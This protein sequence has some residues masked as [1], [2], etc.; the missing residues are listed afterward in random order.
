MTHNAAT[1]SLDLAENINKTEDAMNHQVKREYLKAVYSRYKKESRRGKSKVLD[2]MTLILGC[3]RKW[4]IKLL[5]KNIPES[6]P[7]KGRPHRYPQELLVPI[8]Y[9]LWCKMNRVNSKRFKVALPLWIDFFKD[10]R[11]TPQ[12]RNWLLGMSPATIDRLL[13]HGRKRKGIC[14]TRPSKR[15]LKGIPIQV[16]DWNV[17]RP[18]TVQTDTVAHTHT[19]LDGKFAN[20]ITM[21][22]IHSSWTENRAVWT[23]SHRNM[24]TALREIE[25]A[26]PFNIEVFKSDSG[27]EFMNWAVVGHYQKRIK[28][29]TVVRSRPYRKNDNCYVEQK[30]FTHV[31]EI[32][33]YEKIDQPELIEWMNR[34]YREYWNP[35]HN[36]FL[37][38]QK[39]IRKTRIGSQIKKEY[40]E[41]KTPYQRIL[42]AEV[43]QEHKDALIKNKQSLNPVELSEQLERELKLFQSK[44]RSMRKWAA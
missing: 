4:A 30:N 17:V 13:Q 14:S 19:S 21:T 6:K 24:I 40:D 12:I 38:S 33:G 37:P 22:D 11:I 31:R 29:V 28:P 1:G 16:K 10:P 5:S 26:L 23:K 42:D 8:L 2:E 20:T 44:N 9:E 43:S 35:L 3:T 27:S 36:Y 34:I 32:F 15:F 7:R 18:G 41:P 25:S 39:L